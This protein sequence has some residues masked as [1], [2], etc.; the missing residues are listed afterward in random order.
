MR[1]YPQAYPQKRA[2]KPLARRRRTDSGNDDSQDSGR[3]DLDEDDGGAM[4]GL[5]RNPNLAV[6]GVRT[7]LSSVW[8]ITTVAALY[9]CHKS[10]KRR[11]APLQS[12][13]HLFSS[14]ASMRAS[15]SASSAIQAALVNMR[16][17]RSPTPPRWCRH[18]TLPSRRRGR[19][20]QD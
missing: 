16:I 9:W 5:R 6:E 7:P 8:T 13:N 18:W 19:H 17:K 1:R 4:T 14:R 12:V 3:R 11:Y 2:R 20:P 10:L 15:G